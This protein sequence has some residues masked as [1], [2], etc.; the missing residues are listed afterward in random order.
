M[1]RA[2]VRKVLVVFV[3][4]ELLKSFLDFDS[5][6]RFICIVS[7]SGILDEH[8]HDLALESIIE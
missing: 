4:G 5:Y 3:N 6:C 2:H 7:D 1:K 8:W